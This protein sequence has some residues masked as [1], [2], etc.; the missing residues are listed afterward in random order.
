MDKKRKTPPSSILSFFKKQSTSANVS[1]ENSSVVLEEPCSSSSFIE[2]VKQ[3]GTLLQEVDAATPFISPNDI[4]L[5][6][7]KQVRIIF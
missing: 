7:D 4:G 2:T 6:V 5:F 1:N 3:P